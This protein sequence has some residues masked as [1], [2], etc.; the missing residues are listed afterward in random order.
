MVNEIRN[1]KE[2]R[3][4]MKI[5]FRAAL[6]ML[7]IASF[8]TFVGQLIVSSIT[9]HGYSSRQDV[10]E[11]EFT[12]KQTKLEIRVNQIEEA[13]EAEKALLGAKI[14]ELPSVVVPV[15]PSPARNG[16]PF[17]VESVLGAVVE[18]ICLDNDD[19]DTFYTGSGTVIDSS[20]L[21]LTNQHLLVSKN[22]SMI[23]FCGIG[24]TDDI[25][26]PPKI[27]YIAEITALDPNL[28]LAIM[29]IVE[30]MDG[31]ELPDSFQSILFDGCTQAAQSLKLGDAVYIA[32]YPGIGAE[33][34]TFTTGV[35][36][37]RVGNNLIK[38]SALI[39]SGTS[40][41]A[42]FD[43]NGK[44]IGLPT[45]AARGDIGGSLGYLIAADA[46]DVFLTNFYSGSLNDSI[47]F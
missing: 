36:S 38:T 31:Q 4:S 8:M 44:Y 9:Y 19:K 22:E 21:V 40:G 20:G 41:G 26:F 25:Q 14:E 37:G 30:H 17:S 2:Q 24:F 47:S 39:D 15:T 42:A 43:S 34:F 5:T 28:D 10:D 27:E 3:V 32:G 6:L 33:T 12:Y 29:E 18:I 1:N 7:L 23:R 45:A 16:S 35:V 13:R 11:A 46:I